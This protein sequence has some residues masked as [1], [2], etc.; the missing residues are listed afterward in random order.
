MLDTASAYGIDGAN[1]FALV[2]L[3]AVTP[4]IFAGMRVSLSIAV[5]LLVTSEM[6]A[7]TD[8]IGYFVFLAQQQFAVDDM[9][10]GIILLGL[11]GFALNLLLG[12]L[13]RLVLRGH[14]PPQTS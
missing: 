2:V 5:L 12:L 13:E 9:W 8:G 10:A 1:R 14:R 3:P 6:V 7:S 4:R 11:L